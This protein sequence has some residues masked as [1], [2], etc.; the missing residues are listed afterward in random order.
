MEHFAESADFGLG[1]FEKHG[2][3]SKYTASI[4]NVD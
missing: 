1:R 2:D 4:Q 3:C